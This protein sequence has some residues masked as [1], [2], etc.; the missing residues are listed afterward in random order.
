MAPFRGGRAPLLLRA[1]VTS[2][3][4]KMLLLG[5]RRD[6]LVRE[7]RLECA[8]LLKLGH[9][10]VFDGH[11]NDPPFE[12]NLCHEDRTWRLTPRVVVSDRANA[13]RVTEADMHR[14]GTEAV[15]HLGCVHEAAVFCLPLRIAVVRARGERERSGC[16]QKQSFHYY[17]SLKEPDGETIIL[18]HKYI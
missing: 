10:R 8:V 3:S 5:V 12:G 18:Y 11:L 14:N 13:C 4:E 1:R 9:V 17:H 15:P 7:A 6:E 16:N 2:P